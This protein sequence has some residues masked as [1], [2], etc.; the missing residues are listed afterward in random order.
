[1]SSQ[2]ELFPDAE[3]VPVPM[4]EPAPPYDAYHVLCYWRREAYWSLDPHAFSTPEAARKFAAKMLLAGWIGVHIVHVKVDD[5][6]T[7][8]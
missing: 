8:E 7:K 5:D 4:T 3:A 1:M 2:P 6:P